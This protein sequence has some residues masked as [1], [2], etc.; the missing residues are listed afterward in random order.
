[1]MLHNDKQKMTE[2]QQMIIVCEGML[3]LLDPDE[4]VLVMQEISQRIARSKIK[5]EEPVVITPLRK[6][7]LEVNG[8]HFK[9]VSSACKFYDLEPNKVRKLLRENV[10]PSDIFP[11]DAP[12]SIRR[13]DGNGN[14]S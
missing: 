12:T 5:P 7:S 13:M 2:K 6:L 9:T 10:D 4:L 14:I 1:M 8:R 11:K 3:Q